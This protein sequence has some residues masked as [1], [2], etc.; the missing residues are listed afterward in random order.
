MK[1]IV[2]RRGG[3]VDGG[4]HELV[5]R[6]LAVVVVFRVLVVASRLR[7]CVISRCG[8]STR[9]CL[10]VVGAGVRTSSILLLGTVGRVGRLFCCVSCDGPSGRVRAT[11]PGLERCVWAAIR[12]SVAVGGPGGSVRRRWR[13]GELHCVEG[14]RGRFQDA[15]RPVLEETLALVQHEHVPGE[16]ERSH[17]VGHPARVAGLQKRGQFGTGEPMASIR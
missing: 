13:R 3:G 16:E 4:G 2:D 17:G 10:V 1:P 8:F 9:L 11:V 5:G 14:D 6:G 7:V 12:R 15:G